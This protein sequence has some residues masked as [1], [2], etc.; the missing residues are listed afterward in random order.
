MGLVHWLMLN[1]VPIF[2][3]GIPYI[4]TD[5]LT[6]HLMTSAITFCLGQLGFREALGS[7]TAPY[8][9]GEQATALRPARAHLADPYRYLEK[10]ADLR[11]P[12]L[13]RT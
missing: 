13:R 5:Y 6:T 9:R 4:H 1:T 12:I 2:T 8:N 7:S 11:S 3:L 10:I